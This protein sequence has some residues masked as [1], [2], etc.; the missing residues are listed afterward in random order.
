MI[1]SE[2]RT[3]YAPMRC[4]TVYV[5]LCDDCGRTLSEVERPFKDTP[6][7]RAIRAEIATTVHVCAPCAASMV[8]ELI[9]DVSAS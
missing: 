7:L 1:T 9:A 2:R 3:A 6:E 5:T 4:V 8:D